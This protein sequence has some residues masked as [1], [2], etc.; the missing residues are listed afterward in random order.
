MHY[1]YYYEGLRAVSLLEVSAEVFL[2]G[3]D[4]QLTAYFVT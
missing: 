1:Y 3:I 4:G 2:N